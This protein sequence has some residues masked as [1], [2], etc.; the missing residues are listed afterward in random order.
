MGNPDCK[1]ERD[2]EEPDLLETR[3][4]H[5]QLIEVVP[6]LL[7]HMLSYHLFKPAM[8]LTTCRVGGMVHFGFRL[9]AK[10]L[11]SSLSPKFNGLTQSS[12]SASRNIRPPVWVIRCLFS[13]HIY[14]R[15]VSTE[16]RDQITCRAELVL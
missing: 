1:R 11:K 13:F 14:V 12:S 16:V 9:F 7:P 8:S 15:M 4:V 2:G 3:P 5:R 10:V 6:N